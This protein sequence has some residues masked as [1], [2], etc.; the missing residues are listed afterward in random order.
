MTALKNTY[1]MPVMFIGHG[2]PMNAVISNSFTS[3]LSAAGKDEPA[4][5]FHEGF[6]YSTLS[7]RCLRFS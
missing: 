7:M 2:S 3:H 4:E 5:Y 6:Y 1:L